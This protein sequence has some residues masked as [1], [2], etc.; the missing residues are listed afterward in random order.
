M[1]WAYKGVLLV[2][3]T[4]QEITTNADA[5]HMIL[6]WL[7]TAIKKMHCLLQKMF[8]FCMTLLSHTM[9]ILL[10]N[11]CSASSGKSLEYMAYNPDMGACDYHLYAALKDH[12]G[13]HAFQNEDNC[14]EVVLTAGHTHTSSNRELKS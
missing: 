9:P 12:L 5:Y 4:Q 3:L 10:C 1:F 8:Y 7:R 13:I 11:S 14:D 2:D 6:E